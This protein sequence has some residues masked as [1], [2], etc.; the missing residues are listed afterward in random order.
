[1]ASNNLIGM[2]RQILG[3]KGDMNKSEDGLWYDIVRNEDPKIEEQKGV[4][5]K[6]KFWY[7]EIKDIHDGIDYVYVDNSD[8]EAKDREYLIVATDTDP[9]KIKLPDDPKLGYN[10]KIVDAKG[11]FGTNH[12]TV[13]RNG[14]TIMG[15]DSDLVIDD[16]DENVKL[17]YVDN[18][19]WRF[20]V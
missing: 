5:G 2:L 18:D 1:M 19:D 7:E 16:D 3:S 6:I 11:T 10:I 15:D 8:Y 20:G 4:A 17:V 14:K 13:D 12:V 9:V